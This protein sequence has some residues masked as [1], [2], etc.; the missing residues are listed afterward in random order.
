MGQS[1]GP[2]VVG[3]AEAVTGVE[4][5]VVVGAVVATLRTGA[6]ALHPATMAPDTTT[7]TAHRRAEAGAPRSRGAEAGAPGSRGV[8]PRRPDPGLADR[9]SDKRRYPKPAVAGVLVGGPLSGA[10]FSAGPDNGAT[11]APVG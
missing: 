9:V 11:M 4:G 2:G 5:A 8:G 1:H 7:T 10:G 6:A 3:T